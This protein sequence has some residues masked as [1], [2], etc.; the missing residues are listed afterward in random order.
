MD[1]GGHR[2][3]VSSSCR[4]ALRRLLWYWVVS[5]PNLVFTKYPSQHG[6]LTA[7]HLTHYSNR[8]IGLQ[9]DWQTST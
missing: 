2:D 8:S 5:I 7:P 9:A 6:I 3:T 1:L 4:L